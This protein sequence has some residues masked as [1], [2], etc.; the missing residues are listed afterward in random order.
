MHARFEALNQYYQL[1]T[2]PRDLGLCP[3]S[4]VLT[5]RLPFRRI[6]RHSNPSVV[7]GLV[8]PADEERA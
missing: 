8:V 3:V 2:H 5:E 6:Q 7:V 1:G 4:L